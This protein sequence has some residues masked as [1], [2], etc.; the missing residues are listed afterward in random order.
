[1][2]RCPVQQ[3]P[4]I[5]FAIFSVGNK[6]KKHRIYSLKAWSAIS[7]QN[8]PCHNQQAVDLKHTKS[9]FDLIVLGLDFSLSFSVALTPAIMGL[10]EGKPF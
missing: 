8:S 1:M 3:R 10:Q 5:L 2:D 4:K 7:A 6:K 9:L